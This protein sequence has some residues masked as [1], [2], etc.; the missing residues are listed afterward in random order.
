MSTLAPSFL[1]TSLFISSVVAC[2][3]KSQPQPEAPAEPSTESETTSPPAPDVA[4]A[5]MP[6]GQHTMPDGST[7]PGHQH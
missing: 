1:G 2:G 7:M 5:G 3:G 4:D 6:E